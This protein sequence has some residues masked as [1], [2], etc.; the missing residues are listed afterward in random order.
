MA[1][2]LTQAQ[3]KQLGLAGRHDG[4]VA[5]PLGLGDGGLQQQGHDLEIIRLGGQI[6]L[7]WRLQHDG[8]Q[9]TEVCAGRRGIA[10][11]CCRETAREQIPARSTADVGNVED[12]GS[13]LRAVHLGF[14]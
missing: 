5:A 12:N 8:L 7:A 13:V 1:Q 6:L 9:R 11:P 2:V 3:A 10:C 4:F 14:D